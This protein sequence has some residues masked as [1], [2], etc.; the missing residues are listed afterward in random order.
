MDNI[1]TKVGMAYLKL[2]GIFEFWM[3]YL[4]CWI[5]DI[6]D[7]IFLNAVSFALNM[8][9]QYQLDKFYAITSSDK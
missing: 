9:I 5:L 7:G 3:V 1:A 6:L 2:H 8:K 4:V